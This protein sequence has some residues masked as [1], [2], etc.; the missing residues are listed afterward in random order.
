MAAGRR[1]HVNE[2]NQLESMMEIELLNSLINQI[3][4][5]IKY[6]KKA[7]ERQSDLGKQHNR[8]TDK[9]LHRWKDL[10]RIF[11]AKERAL[12]EQVIER[13]QLNIVDLNKTLS[14]FRGL[15]KM[16]DAYPFYWSAYYDDIEKALHQV[17]VA[18]KKIDKK[19]HLGNF[20]P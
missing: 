13:K 10:I 16:F 12:K 17:F 8:P 7:P 1:R 20:S 3:G 9:E 15:S 6:M 19:Y 2:F 14:F 11:I 18:R 5:L 4:I